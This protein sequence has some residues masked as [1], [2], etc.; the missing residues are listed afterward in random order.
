MK[1]I[2]SILIMICSLAQIGLPVLASDQ[3]AE[4]PEVLPIKPSSDPTVT[5]SA[6]QTEQAETIPEPK[7]SLSDYADLSH[8]EEPTDFF[9]ALVSG[10]V[11]LNNRFRFEF[12]ENRGAR[13]SY[14]ITNRIRLG[15]ESQPWHGLN[16]LVEMENVASPDEDLYFVPQT[17][18]GEPGRTPVP[19]PT[20]TEV[21]QAYLRYN[22]KTLPN[23]NISLDVKTG[24]QRT[25]LDDSRFVGN[26]GW[27]QFEQTLDSVSI[28]SN[29]GIENFTAYYAYVWRVQRIFGPNGPNFDSNSHL[30]NV[31]YKV[32]PELTVTPF[33]YLLDF[34]N[35]ALNSSASYGVRLHGKVGLE[36]ATDVEGLSFDYDFTYAYQTDF[37]NNPVNY[38]ANFIGV[39][40]GLA[41]KG[42]GKVGA[43]Y[44]LLGSDGGNFAFRFPLGTNHKFQGWADVFVVTPAAGVQDL[45][46]YV[47]GDLPWKTKGAL[48]FHKF[49]S[50]QGGADFGWEVDASLGKK[51]TENLSILAKA[52]Y[53][54]GNGGPFAD[55]VRFWTELTFKF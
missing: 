12:A 14:A 22:T 54:D 43:G 30:I 26:V 38:D 42:T 25:I 33:I 13:P 34:D 31:G 28:K 27:R 23:T 45:Y 46:V 10:K 44:Q 41:L 7:K 20:A 47:K 3:P 49:Y 5:T 55:R 21:N 11:L 24:R 51:V 50:D 8:G 1:H 4:T 32:I 36:Q 17:G 37:A 39:D 18:Q 9:D 48:I 19:D 29:L 52:A 53:Y 40:L 2:A 16:F 6:T 15:Y 35:S